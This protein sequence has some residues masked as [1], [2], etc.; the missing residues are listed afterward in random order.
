MLSL[1]NLTISYGN[2]KLFDKFSIEFERGAINAVL[3]QSGVGKSSLLHCLTG[4]DQKKHF[5]LDQVEFDCNI[6]NLATKVALMSQRPLLLPWAS[7][8]KNVY[9]GAR[10]RGDKSIP[11]KQKAQDIIEALGLLSVMHMKPYQLS[12]GM[13]QRVSLGQ[14]LFEGREIVLLDEPFSALD[15]V[16]KQTLYSL[17][18]KVFKNKTVVLITHDPF[19]ALALAKQIYILKG[20]PAE[21]AWHYCNKHRSQDPWAVAQQMITVITDE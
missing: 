15:M 11:S 4:L 19:E 10:L 18:K 20:S 9:L 13:Q 21:V 12:G 6:E 3:G 2:R 5:G 17:V 16:T 8:L 14:V 7:T 1:K